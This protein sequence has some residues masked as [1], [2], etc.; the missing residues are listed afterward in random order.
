MFTNPD[1]VFIH[2][3]EEHV[4]NTSRFKSRKLY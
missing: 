3:R 4:F 2:E 1:F